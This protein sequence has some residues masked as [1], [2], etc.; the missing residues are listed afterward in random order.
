[1]EIMRQVGVSKPTIWRWQARYTQQGV[2]GLL[3]DATRP[4]GKAPVPT[5]KVRKVVELTHSPPPWEATHWTLCVM[6]EQVGLAWS[7]LRLIWR[8]HGLVPHRV[9]TFKLSRDP[10]FADKLHDVVG[11]YV[12]HPEHAVF[13]SIDESEPRE[14][15][16]QAL[17]RTQVPSPMKPDRPETRTRDYIRHGTTTLFA[18]LNILDG[19]VIGQHYQRHRQEEFISFL[20]HTAASFEDQEVHVFLENCSTHKTAKVHQWLAEH[21][22]WTLHFTPTSASWLNAVEGLSAKLSSRRLKHAIF[23]S[24]QKC[25]A[26]ILRFIEEHNGREAKPFRWTADPESIVAARRKGFALID[27]HH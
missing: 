10:A 19:M 1:M 25:E 15:Q 14:R 27:S 5:S 24:L 22:N 12:N 17:D 16:I 13:L 20:D 18:T 21:P 23:K 8:K 7:T 9:R 2:D 3:R 6:A 26:A 4:P 11:R